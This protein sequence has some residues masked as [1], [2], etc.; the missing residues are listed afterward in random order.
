MLIIASLIERETPSD[1]ERPLV[2]SVIY[3]R[4]AARRAA[5][6]DATIRYD[7]N[8]WSRPLQGV[9]ARQGHAVQHADQPGLPPTPIGNPGLASMKA[10]AKPG[11]HRLPV[12]R[13][14]ARRMPRVR[15]DQRAARAQ[16]GRLRAGAGGERRQGAAA[17]VLTYLGVAGWPVAHSRSPRMHNA[18]LAAAGLSDWRYL[19][20][21]LPPERFAETVRALPAAGFRGINVTIPHKEAALALADAATPTAAAVGAANTLTFLPRAGSTPTT[22]TSPGCSRR[23]PSTRRPHARW[24]S[25]RAAPRARRSTRCAVR[26]P[27]T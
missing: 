9:R 3:N 16:R 24:C 21:P 13:R 23:C 25:A 19:R 17:E 12:L 14:Q 2:A 8:N 11:E 22:P 15:R 7:E 27:P 1:R 26:A 20:L 10:A 18:A 6:I 4:L 5:E